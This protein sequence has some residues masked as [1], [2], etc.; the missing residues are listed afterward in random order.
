LTEVYLDFPNPHYTDL[1]KGGAESINL[2]NSRHAVHSEYR[3]R[4]TG[5]IIFQASLSGDL[6]SHELCRWLQTYCPVN[7]T[8]VH[9][10]KLVLRAR[11]LQ[12]LQGAIDGI[13]V[14]SPKLKQ[15]GEQAEPEISTKVHD[16]RVVLS[17]SKD[18]ARNEQTKNDATVAQK[19]WRSIERVVAGVSR[20]IET[21]LLSDD[22]T[23]FDA[24]TD[25]LLKIIESGSSPM[26]RRCLI[27]ATRSGEELRIDRDLVDLP[28][29]HQRF[30]CG[31]IDGRPVLVETF[32][33]EPHPETA[34]PYVQTILQV[35]KMANLICLPKEPFYHILPGRG[36]VQET[37]DDRIG[38]VFEIPEMTDQVEGPLLLSDL[39]NHAEFKRVALGK[40]IQLALEVVNAVEH[41]HRLQWLHKELRSSNIIFLRNTNGNDE[42]NFS[43]PWLCGF[44]YARSFEDGTR[45][46][47][48]HEVLNN[49]YRHPDRWGKPTK[50]YTRAHDIYSLGVILLEIFSWQSAKDIH[51]KSSSKDGKSTRIHSERIKKTYLKKVRQDVPHLAGSKIATVVEDCLDFD[52][53]TTVLS[54]YEIQLFFQKQILDRIAAVAGLL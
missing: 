16:L 6:D 8:S 5:S 11:T 52:T 46:D 38:L 4:S 15:L 7:V 1:A 17:Q 43:Q 9:I 13:T 24:G 2:R 45:L 32:A 37:L 28:G 35:Q 12:H 54:E 19:A 48:D 49:L 47:E 25:G 33:Y 50:T 10:E 14:D 29:G 42:I 31:R 27:S 44:E 26:M 39:Y 51:K 3:K 18:S 20:A 41:L 53:K 34:E 23:L 30:R 40:R 22:A 36:Y 21:A